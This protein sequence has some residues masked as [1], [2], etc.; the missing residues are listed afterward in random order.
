MFIKLALHAFTP[1]GVIF[2]SSATGT[3]VMLSVAKAKQLAFPRGADV[4][5]K[6]WVMALSISAAP[7][8]L[9]AVAES[10]ASSSFV[11]LVLS[12]LIPLMSLFFITVVFRE[13]AIS[14]IR[15]IGFS[16]GIVGVLMM[17]GIWNGLGQNLWWA[18]VAVVGA[19]V[20]VGFSYPFCRKHLMDLGIDPV[21][22]AASQLILTT[23]TLLPAFLIDGRSSHRVPVTAIVGV[24]CLGAL[25]NGFAYMWNFQV[26]REAGSS[27]ASTVNFLS[28]VVAIFCGVILLNEHLTWNEPVGGV[29]IL[30]GVAVGQGR[31]KTTSSRGVPI[32]LGGTRT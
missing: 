24:L 3:V 2:L 10:H 29:V 8:V 27:V 7:G 13:E 22:L 6:L 20:L 19:S 9:T 28:P 25:A 1:F 14:R 21:V 32:G 18:I 17:F 15:L 26:I 5:I 11:G 23:C 16:L 4:W 12:G 31:L 30:F